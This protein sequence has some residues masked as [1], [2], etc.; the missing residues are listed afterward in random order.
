MFTTGSSVGGTL[1]LNSN[2]IKAL[3]ANAFAGITVQN[4]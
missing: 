1:H 4:V 3:P 2:K